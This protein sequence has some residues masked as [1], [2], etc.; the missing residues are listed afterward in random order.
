MGR[1]LLVLCNLT[2][3][4]KCRYDYQHHAYLVTPLKES[5]VIQARNED[6]ETSYI[7][8]LFRCSFLNGRL[9]PAFTPNGSL[10]RDGCIQP[11]SGLAVSIL[12]PFLHLIIALTSSLTAQVN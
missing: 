8:C 4:G 7:S 2:P 5:C 6:I 3:S 12:H 1:L 9:K 10:R 11:P